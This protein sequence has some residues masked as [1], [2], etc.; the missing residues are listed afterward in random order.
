MIFGT[1]REVAEVVAFLF[2]DESRYVNGSVVEV[3]GGMGLR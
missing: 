2:S 3:D 1:A